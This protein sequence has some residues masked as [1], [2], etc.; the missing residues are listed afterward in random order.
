MCFKNTL[1]KTYSKSQLYRTHCITKKRLTL[2][3]AVGEPPVQSHCTTNYTLVFQE[4]SS[5]LNTVERYTQKST[6]NNNSIQQ[7]RNVRRNM[8]RVLRLRSDQWCRNVQSVSKAPAECRKSVLD[9]FFE[10]FKWSWSQKSGS[11]FSQIKSV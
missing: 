11:V 5:S 7:I 1:A 2:L 10:N 6:N 4:L 8:Y 9:E 3:H